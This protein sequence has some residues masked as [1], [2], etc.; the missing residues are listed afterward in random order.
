[1]TDQLHQAAPEGRPETSI[2]F[3]EPGKRNQSLYGLG[4][5]SPPNCLITKG[6]GL[7]P[8]PPQADRQH[9]VHPVNPV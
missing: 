7:L 8:D 6:D 5:L 9:P 1:L 4:L 2:R 3:A